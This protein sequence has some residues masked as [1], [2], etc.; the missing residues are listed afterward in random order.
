MLAPKKHYD[1]HVKDFLRQIVVPRGALHGGG[2]ASNLSHMAATLPLYFQNL[3]HTT[4]L[5]DCQLSVLGIT[6]DAV[7]Q[8]VVLRDKLGT[9]LSLL[10]WACH[11]GLCSHTVS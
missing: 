4:N 11:C 7:L 8:V 6:S 10:G 5:P 2:L 1:D 9:S 3:S